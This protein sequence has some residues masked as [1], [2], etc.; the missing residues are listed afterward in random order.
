MDMFP[1]LAEKK[2][3]NSEK[4][5]DEGWGEQCCNIHTQ[6]MRSYR[7]I[8]EMVISKTGIHGENM[9]YPTG[10]YYLELVLFDAFGVGT[11]PVSL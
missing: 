7:Y 1:R 4:R 5:G 2:K 10:G 11:E 9:L 3:I 6:H 8:L